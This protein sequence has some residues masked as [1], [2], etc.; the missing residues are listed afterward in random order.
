[1]VAKVADV[2]ELARKELAMICH[3]NDV[4]ML[5]ALLMSPINDNGQNVST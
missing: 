2:V 3:G 1:M 5:L 4:P